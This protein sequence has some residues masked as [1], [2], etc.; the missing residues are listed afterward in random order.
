MNLKCVSLSEKHRKIFKKENK[1]LH[2]FELN[3]GLLASS[4]PPRNNSFS[5]KPVRMTS[6][7]FCRL[8]LFVLTS[9]LVTLL[10]C[11]TSSEEGVNISGKI[12]INGQPVELGHIQFIPDNQAGNVVSAEIKNGQYAAENVPIGP[13]RVLVAANKS[14][15]ILVD[16]YGEMV[17][18]IVSILPE[19][20]R[21]GITKEVT[22]STENMDFELD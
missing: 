10:G 9:V 1:F 19:K 17:P 3:C 2:I 21:S 16:V 14:T 15:G 8:K 7:L 4:V 11:G 20:Y 18:E 5:W 13:L 22:A 12:T 6:A